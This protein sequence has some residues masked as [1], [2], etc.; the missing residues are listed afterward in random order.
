MNELI[1][2]RA[3]RV[4]VRKQLL[5][6]V[7]AITLTTY[8]AS[9]N[10]AVAE[11]ANRPTVWVELGG[12]LEFLQG[13]SS[14]FTAP[15]MSITPTP[16][17]YQ[18]VSPTGTQKPSSHGFG[19]EG[20]IEFQP[21]A[22]DW[23]FSVG[24]RYGR[25]HAK[26]H[27]HQQ[28]GLPPLPFTYSAFG[29]IGHATK[30]FNEQA[31]ADSRLLANESHAVIDFQAGKDVGLGVFGR[32]GSSTF[33]AG[34]RFAQFS[35]KSAVDILAHPTIDV[36][37]AKLFGIITFPV[38]AFHAYTMHARAERSFHGIGPSLSWNAS[39]ALLGNDH[40]QLDLDWGINAALLFGRQKAKTSHAT[41]A[42]YLTGK[43]VYHAY[44]Q[45]YPP[46][47]TD[48]PLRSRSV[49]APNLGGFAGISVKYPNAKISL[50]YRADFFFGAVDAG[51]DQRQTKDL[52]FH[53]PF[54]T[55][56]IGLGG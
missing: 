38:S 22:S 48:N 7:S 43:Q 56:S 10:F 17:P 30:I 34:V 44:V 19:L 35:T 45:A 42:Y 41:Q 40:A 13:T 39:A 50:G 26:R 27:L 32:Q 47:N 29:S 2:T 55:L 54:A 21:E 24:I 46:R 14:P 25:S 11:D 8:I 20:K 1:D 31:F 15:F 12:Q 23:I 33:S 18:H 16:E 49:I 28:T 9:T 51:I 36:D 3:N 5:A 37:Y 4:I 52:G 53:G 6:T